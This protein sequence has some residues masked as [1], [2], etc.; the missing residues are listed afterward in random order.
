MTE[1]AAVREAVLEARSARAAVRIVGRGGWLDAGR[2]VAASTPLS[3]HALTGILEYTPGDLTLTARAGTTLGEIDRATRSEGQWLALDPF[4]GDEGTLGATAATA[5]AG[6]LSQAFGLPRDN[7]LGIEFVT[8]AGSVVR[9]GGRVVKNVAGFDLTRLLV[10]SWGTL[11]IIT[12]VTVR[13]RARPEV[14]ETLALALPR[15]DDLDGLLRRLRAA[16][17]A[18]LALEILSATIARRLGIGDSDVILA[19]FGGNAER[20]RAQRE[21]LGTIGDV[22]AVENDVWRALRLV[23][24][25]AATVV[26]YSARPSRLT[27]TVGSAMSA[28]RAFDGSMVHATVGRGVA[29]CIIPDADTPRLSEALTSPFEGSRIFERLPPS[30]WST[31]AAG[32][33]ADRLSIRVKRAFDPDGLLN[34]HILGAAS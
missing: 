22:V 18:P 14:D 26:R 12:E 7:V 28:A 4:G 21:A 5:S 10:G 27:Q 25:P 19:R 17:I 13:L 32:S 8:G 3:L 20:V 9:G 31:V 6:P 34:P 33:A 24:P 30:L 16:P 23:E 2:P 29:R 15:I 1:T 11:G